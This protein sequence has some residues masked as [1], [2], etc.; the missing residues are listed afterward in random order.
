MVMDFYFGLCLISM[1]FQLHMLFYVFYI[2]WPKKR[3]KPANTHTKKRFNSFLQIKLYILFHIVYLIR[4][5]I[6]SNNALSLT[7]VQTCLDHEK[8]EITGCFSYA[9]NC[10]PSSNI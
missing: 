3:Q 9:E 1:V 8:K 7:I 4:L 5:L 2:V 6:S 10:L